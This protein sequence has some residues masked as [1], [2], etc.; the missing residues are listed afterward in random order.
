MSWSERDV[1][2]TNIHR[3][4]F[5]SATSTTAIV[6]IALFLFLSF[7]LSPREI[8]DL[9]HYTISFIDELA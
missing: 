6:G 8:I 3:S 7:S 5:Y 9:S 1:N 4:I 2:S